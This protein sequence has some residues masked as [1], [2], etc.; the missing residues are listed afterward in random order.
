MSDQRFDLSS[1]IFKLNIDCFDELFEWLSRDDLDALGQTCKLLQL[2]VGDH[3]QR[4]F[5]AIEVRAEED[6]LYVNDTRS[7]NFYR[8]AQKLHS[9][10]KYIQKVS[11]CENSIGI[12]D[13]VRMFCYVGTNCTTSIKHI[14]FMNVLLTQIEL[15]WIEK[16]LGTCETISIEDCLIKRQFYEKFPEHCE[17]LRSLYVKD[18]RWNRNVLKRTGNDWLQRHYPKLNHLSW[19]QSS[20]KGQKIDE[21]RTFFA[22]NPQVVSF[23]TSFHCFWNNRDFID[24]ANVKLQ[25]L[26]IEFDDWTW[27]PR[28]I[29]ETY[30]LLNNLHAKGIYERLNLYARYHNLDY[31]GQMT[32]LNALHSL[33]LHEISERYNLPQLRQLKELRIQYINTDLDNLPKQLPNLERV[34]L[35]FADTKHFLPFIYQSAKLKEMKIDFVCDRA[36]FNCVL[37]VA[38]MHKEREKLMGARKVVIFIDEHVFLATK[39]STGKTEFGLIEIERGYKHVWNRKMECF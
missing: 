13:G 20:K 2:I 34:Y 29:T 33:H 15:V 14:Q 4:N 28:N 27:T 36:T 31:F 5:P 26:T 25:D 11:L 12:E 21:L 9:F 37:D 3:F 24:Q 19:T 38:S 8:S 18:C 35:K 6:G 30:R 39:W 17:N 7:A 32:S 1:N 16:I 23:S 10:D 22:L